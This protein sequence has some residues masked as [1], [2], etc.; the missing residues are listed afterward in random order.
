M[1]F[2][3]LTDQL[4]F[5]SRTR[6]LVEHRYPGEAVLFSSAAT[7][8]ETPRESPTGWSLR[9]VFQRRG[10]I[11]ITEARIFVQ[12]SFLSLFT[13][14]WLVA[15][16]Y[17]VHQYLQ[18]GHDFHMVLTIVA[19]TFIVQRRPYSRDLP[20]RSIDRIHFGS[21][22]GMTGLCDIMSVVV[23]GRAIQLC[24]GQFVPGAIRERLA[25]LNDSSSMR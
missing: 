8:L 4:N 9:R 1:M 21:V 14:M 17:S 23:R 19:A 6:S 15:I 13:A 12:S 25:S 18:S 11:V 7:I 22:R 10:N 24:V 3:T 20:F 16:G 5:A 2:R